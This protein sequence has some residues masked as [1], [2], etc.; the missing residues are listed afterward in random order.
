MVLTGTGRSRGRPGRD[1]QRR[2]RVAL[3]GVHGYGAAHLAH[4]GRLAG[5][6][7]LVAVADP[8]PPSPELPAGTRVFSD[9]R[10]LLEEIEDLDVVIVCT[11]IHLHAPLTRLALSAGAD[12]LLEKPPFAVLQD[13]SEIVL[14]ATQLGRAVQVGFQSL[15]SSALTAFGTD[16]FGLGAITAV[17]TTGR[18]RRDLAYWRRSAWSGRRELDGI[19][20]VDGAL[21]NPFAHALATA[22]RLAGARRASD[23]ADIEL[24]QYR[25]NPIEVDDTSVVRLVTSTGV[26]VTCAAT[27]CAESER[28]PAIAVLAERADAEFS[29][30]QDLVTVGATEHRFDRTDLLENLL[31]HRATGVPLLSSLADAGA[32]MAVLERIR[33]SEPPAPVAAEWRHQDG[34]RYAVLPGADALVERAARHHATFSELGAPWA[35]SR[36]D[37][38]L[39]E[40]ELDGTTVG[41]IN[42][43]AGA[44]PSSSPR[45]YL[46]RLRTNRGVTVSAAH[47]AD[48]DWH[49]GLGVGI[50]DV[51]GIN[52]W[53]G[54]SYLPGRGYT[55]RNN[56]GRI[57]TTRLTPTGDSVLH[58]LDW[59]R[60]DTVILRERRRISYE[61]RGPHWQLELDVELTAAGAS[62][63]TLSTP[64]AKGRQGAG[65]GGIFWRMPDC[66]AVD[67]RSPLGSGE[68]MV[69]GGISRWLAWSADFEAGPATLAFR[70]GDDQT[71]ADPWFV[72]QRDYPAVGSALAWDRPVSISPAAPLR[73]SL[74][75]LVADGIL[76]D[77]E[78][79]SW[80]SG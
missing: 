48:H 3:I 78:V 35:R 14:L 9:P 75:I 40:L 74:T 42:D 54:R 7:E 1:A 4:L 46:D 8:L 6:V 39:A 60:G 37:T 63:V 18:W 49:L 24:D 30:T 64:G 31:E 33:L 27:L 5:H 17:S 52:F 71:A 61:S 62:D 16:A 12:V 72:R 69:H 36:R 13:H 11:P 66:R 59:L 22:L 56:H 47:P 2:H 41:I 32:F 25:A 50:P 55:W 38:V 34:R 29:Y 77:S 80:A 68:D 28:P 53:G 44:A 67:V 45:P 23:V 73:R 51:D 21:T 10:T 20:V 26:S 15:G 79:E 43:G 58:E 76:P 19:A 70:A 57:R 65:Y